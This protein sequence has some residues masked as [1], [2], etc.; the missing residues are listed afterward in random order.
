MTLLIFYGRGLIIVNITQLYIIKS[1]KIFFI[2]K[3]SRCRSQIGN[4]NPFDKNADWK[5]SCKLKIRDVELQ[6]LDAVQIVV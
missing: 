6:P 5:Q 2:F 1:S 3:F 4:I